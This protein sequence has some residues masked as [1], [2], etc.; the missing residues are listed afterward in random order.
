MRIILMGTPDFA[1]MS[2]APLFDLSDQIV[3][4]YTQPPRPAGRGHKLQHSAVH[5][6]AQQHEVP[7]HTPVSLKSADEQDILRAYEPDMIIVCAYGLILPQAVLDICPCINIHASLLPRWRGAS[8]I[9]SAILHGD[10]ETGITI[11]EMEAGLDSGAMLSSQS[12]PITPTTTAGQLHDAL[13]ALGARM[14]TEAVAQFDSL[15]S[16]I[17]DESLVTYAPKIAKSDAQ[18]DW[19]NDADSVCRHI[20]AYSPFPGAFCHYN[21]EKTT[22]IRLKILSALTYNGDIPPL[23]SSASA[24]TLL[25][26]SSD[27][28]GE[29]A[30]LCG[31]GLLI[32]QQVQRAGG[33][34]QSWESFLHGLHNL[35]SSQAI[36]FS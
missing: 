11:M 6:L 30:I 31:Q 4:V 1:A 20:H 34:V 15:S 8:P 17:Q 33:G 16:V 29:Y 9:Q 32:P 21:D 18:I 28:P 12:T 27:S 26:L 23:T 35:H 24:G 22:P 36:T 3:A 14:I 2:L 13:A 19:T 10:A 25:A 5:T 7:V